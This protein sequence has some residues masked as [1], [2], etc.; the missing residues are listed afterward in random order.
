MPD[1]FYRDYRPPAGRPP[2]PAAPASNTPPNPVP[3]SQMGPA[4]P[5]GSPPAQPYAAPQPEAYPGPPQQPYGA[6]PAQ[7]YPGPG[8]QPYAGAPAQPYAAQPPQAYPGAQPYAAYAPPMAAPFATQTITAPAPI[9]RR[10][11]FLFWLIPAIAVVVAGALTFAIVTANK[12]DKSNKSD[13]NNS[14]NGPADTGAT[15]RVG[16]E[17]TGYVDLSMSDWSEVTDLSGQAPTYGM[18][19][20]LWA[21]GRY[22][23]IT[24]MGYGQ[25]NPDT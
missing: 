12:S 13:K 11:G 7:A 22:D 2:E 25:V 18:P 21:R 23:R 1:P 4:Q 17:E 19:A 6:P 20:K 10:K 16:G 3:S 15:E 9:R 24:M 5:Y 14:Q 8:A